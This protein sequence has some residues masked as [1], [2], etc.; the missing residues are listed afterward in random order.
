L[1]SIIHRTQ[2]MRILLTQF[3]ATLAPWKAVV[4]RQSLVASQ[5]TKVQ[6]PMSSVQRLIEYFQFIIYHLI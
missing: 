1:P 4:S 3:I 2:F 6:R 5:M